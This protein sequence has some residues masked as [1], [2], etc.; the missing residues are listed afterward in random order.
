MFYPKE[1]LAGHVTFLLTE[2]VRVPFV[3]KQSGQLYS[4]S[5]VLNSVEALLS[6]TLYCFSVFQS[7]AMEET[8]I[9]EQHTVTLHR[10]G[11]LPQMLFTSVYVKTMSWSLS[12]PCLFGFHAPSLDF[13]SLLFSGSH[14]V[15]RM[16][17]VYTV[18]GETD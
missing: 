5:L 7:A 9:W 11:I 6:I 2:S 13:S 14:H 12:L 1:T 16:L 17:T 4:A 10:V 18:A 15:R 8:V 3:T